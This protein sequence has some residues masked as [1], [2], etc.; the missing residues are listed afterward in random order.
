MPLPNIIISGSI[1]LGVYRPRAVT[2]ACPMNAWCQYEISAFREGCCV[3]AWRGVAWRGIH[4]QSH[5]AVCAR[6]N[7]KVMK[8]HGK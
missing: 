1:T 8:L 7:W 4:D 3:K 6:E 5:R 2:C